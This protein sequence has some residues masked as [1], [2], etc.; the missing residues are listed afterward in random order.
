M[1]SSKNLCRDRGKSDASGIMETAGVA[2]RD[3]SAITPAEDGRLRH[4]LEKIY[5]KKQSVYGPPPE[6]G[7]LSNSQK[8]LPVAVKKAKAVAAHGASIVVEQKLNRLRKIQPVLQ[9]TR[10]EQAQRLAGELTQ[11]RDEQSNGPRESQESQAQALKNFQKY[12]KRLNI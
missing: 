5:L 6:P 10:E 8:E 11:S 12:R 4:Q 1:K 3:P 9:R 2:R 7:A